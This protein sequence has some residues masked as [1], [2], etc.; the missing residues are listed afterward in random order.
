MKEH[1]T[2]A[3]VLLSTF[4]VTV[5]CLTSLPGRVSFTPYV[6]CMRRWAGTSQRSGRV[7]LAARCRC[8][9]SQVHS[10]NIVCELDCS[11]AWQACTGAYPYRDPVTRWLRPI[12]AGE[13]VPVWRKPDRDSA[14]YLHTCNQQ[15]FTGPM[16]AAPAQ[17]P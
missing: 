12:Q 10:S 11:A 1:S 17:G 14:Y 16:L 5:C 6:G 7:A 4:T 2:Q 15:C 3:C 13:M 9:S 8:H